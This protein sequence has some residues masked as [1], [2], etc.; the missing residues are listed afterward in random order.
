[1]SAWVTVPFAVVAAIAAAGIY[2][3][4]LTRR[5]DPGTRWAG[6]TLPGPA[7]AER[8][9]LDRL[10]GVRAAPPLAPLPLETSPGPER[11]EPANGRGSSD[12]RSEPPG[13]G[14]PTEEKR[15][16][17]P[18][19]GTG[20]VIYAGR[21]ALR[22]P[23]PRPAKPSATARVPRPD[24]TGERLISRARAILPPPPPGQTPK[25]ARDI[26]GHDDNEQAVE[27]MFTRAMAAQVREMAS[28]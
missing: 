27:S 13:P 6:Y 14:E 20:R 26:I 5:P 16:P 12:G 7:D 4:H 18:A 3:G 24:E 21:P 22:P 15:Q 17:W 8:E 23:A 10:R 19:S 9:S 1:M 2:L 25:W 28:D 11:P